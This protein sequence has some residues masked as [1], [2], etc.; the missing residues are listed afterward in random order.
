MCEAQF[1]FFHFIANYK[2]LK[3]LPV[4]YIPF[5]VKP[6]LLKLRRKRLKLLNVVWLGL[7]KSSIVAYKRLDKAVVLRVFPV[8]KAPV[9]KKPFYVAVSPSSRIAGVVNTLWKWVYSPYAGGYAFHLVLRQL[10][11]LVNEY[12]VV[13]NA[14][15]SVKVAVPVAVHEVDGAAVHKP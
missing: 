12:H 5:A 4:E 3:K 14:L 13:L 2:I 9:H 6:R 7:H 15:N 10:R 8:L 11:G 1:T